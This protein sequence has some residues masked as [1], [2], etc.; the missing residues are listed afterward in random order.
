MNR[1]S[2]L[3]DG[4]QLTG[5]SS[6]SGIG[7]YVRELVN[8]LADI[9][10]I[11][12]M[13]L[14][15]RETEL[16]AGVTRLPVRRRWRH[17]RRSELEHEILRPIALMHNRADV[18]HSPNFVVSA[19]QRSPW[20]ATLYDL[21]PL[22][23]RDDVNLAHLRSHML[24]FGRRMAR[25]DAVIAISRFA[26]DAGI[27]QFG[28]DASRVHVCHLGVGAEFKPEGPGVTEDAPYLLL[29]SEYQRRK[30]FDRAFAVIDSLAEA[31]YPH[32]LKVAGRVN[33]WV[34]EELAS[35]TAAVSHPGRIQILG[36]VE[37]LAALYRGATVA[38]IP[39]RYEGFGL[40]ALEAM[41]SG[42]PVVAFDNSAL[43][44][45][46]GEGGLLAPEGDLEAMVKLV[47]GLLDDPSR[48]AEQAEAGLAWASG[49][50]WE[51]CAALHAE[52]YRSLAGL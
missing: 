23:V 2:V 24:R 27:R 15:T 7:T 45:I 22:V 38:L 42:C 44:E 32:V 21:A 26:A 52:V 34:E 1:P 16:P 51:T 31:G 13:V 30:G 49:F 36:F 25:A 19:V 33:P 17:G 35:M 10:D 18:Y 12:L 28:L 9:G 43:G 37:D 14:A 50:S 8:G 46:V 48:R 47:R 39:S 41:A 4:I 6:R 11:S 40:P 29:V 5:Q 20:V 3:I